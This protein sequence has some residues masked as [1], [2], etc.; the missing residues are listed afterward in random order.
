MA[1]FS[2]SDDRNDLLQ[3]CLAV[4]LRRISRA[5]ETKIPVHIPNLGTALLV[6]RI[7][8]VVVDYVEERSIYALMGSRSTYVCTH[9]RVRH[10]ASCAP[11]A[12]DADSRDV[13]QTLEAQLAAAE[14]R[15][16]D[17]RVLLRALSVR[18]TALWPFPQRSGVCT[19]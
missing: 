12:A 6:A 16:V 15:L 17:P 11:D 18:R 19:G 5:S 14:R 4:V 13:I 3:R 2:V 1:I 10:G 7:G 8:S 9:R